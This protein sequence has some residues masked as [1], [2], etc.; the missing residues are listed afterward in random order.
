MAI[1]YPSVSSSTLP[2][3]ATSSATPYLRRNSAGTVD[4]H[5]RIVLA[6]PNRPT[7]SPPALPRAHEYAASQG[8]TG[9]ARSGGRVNVLLAALQLL[10]GYQWLVSG[11]DKLLYGHFPDQMRQLVAGAI[12]SGRL[13]DFFA[14]FLQSAVLPNATIF[15]VL[16]ECGEMLTGLG[17]LAGVLLSMTRPPIL[18]RLTAERG[19]GARFARIALGALYVLTVVAALGALFMGLNY[20]ALDG[21]PMPWFAPGLAYGGAIH[22]ALFLAGASATILIGQITSQIAAAR[23]H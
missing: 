14:Q 19:S 13:P 12:S 2:A 11:G 3:R 10:V 22:P 15:G 18:R 5:E 21:M 6:P 16:V 8:Q 23:Q 1:P 4:Y 7:N 17:L 9:P 20:W